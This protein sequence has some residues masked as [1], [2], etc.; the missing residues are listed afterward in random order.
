[1][2]YIHTFLFQLQPFPE[3]GFKQFFLFREERIFQHLFQSAAVMGC[4]RLSV[5]PVPLKYFLI[6]ENSLKMDPGP[7]AQ[8]FP[9]F[10]PAAINIPKTDDIRDKL[11]YLLSFL[12]DMYFLPFHYTLDLLSKTII[13]H[14]YRYAKVSRSL[15]SIF[16][17]IRLIWT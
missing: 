5:R 7:T 1:M 2:N 6:H 15:T 9:D 11:P 8:I 3:H 16:F 13:P 4:K 12:L 17:S 10:K 14:I